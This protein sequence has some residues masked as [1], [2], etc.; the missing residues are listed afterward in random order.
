[1]TPHTHIH[2]NVHTHT[3]ALGPQSRGPQNNSHV[4]WGEGR[5]V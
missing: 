2:M 5:F 1:M 3:Y 4:D